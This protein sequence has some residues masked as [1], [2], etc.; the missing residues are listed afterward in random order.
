M[1]YRKKLWDDLAFVNNIIKLT[2]GTRIEKVI[3][4]G[5]EKGSL[6]DDTQ[7]C[8]KGKQ[9]DIEIKRSGGFLFLDTQKSQYTERFSQS[10]NSVLPDHDGVLILE[11]S[12]LPVP[13]SL[14]GYRYRIQFERFESDRF[15]CRFLHKFWQAGGV[16]PDFLLQ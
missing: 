11:T 16:R 9:S 4:K 2:D 13:R 15:V 8:T 10:A 5:G 1:I 12:F 3:S 7:E 14:K 6:L